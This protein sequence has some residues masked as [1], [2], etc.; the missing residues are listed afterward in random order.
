V[1]LAAAATLLAAIAVAETGTPAIAD[2]SPLPGLELPVAATDITDTDTNLAAV[3]NE[4][5]VMT[6]TEQG[7]AIHKLRAR[8][9]ADAARLASELNA[10]PGVVA[11]PNAVLAV[12]DGPGPASDAVKSAGRFA[13]DQEPALRAASVPALVSEQYGAAQWGLRAVNAEAAWS[14]TRGG[15][16]T[17]AVIDSGVDA[18]HPDLAGRLL[19]QIDLVADGWTGD[20]DGHGTHVAG[21]IAA[22]LDGV[23]VAGLANQVTVLPVRVLDATGVGDFQT[24]ALGIIEAVSAGARV[25]NL[26]LGSSYNSAVQAQAVQYAIDSGVTVIAAGGN[27]YAE[28]NPT[29]YPAALP[30]VVAVSAITPEGGS[31][32][33]ANCGSY[34]DIAAPGV[35]IL[36]TVPGVGWD[37]KDGTS[38]AAP[39]V[40]AAAA[41][42]RAGN[43][44]LTRAKVDSVLLGTVVDDADGDGRDNC[45]GEGLLQADRAVMAAA[46]MP[47][48]IRATP[49]VTQSTVPATV[50]VTAVSGKSKLKVDVNP[51]KG[52]GYWAF[53]VHKQ[54][55]DGSWQRLKTYKTR[56]SKETRTINLPRG[57]Y[58][59]V[60]NAKYGH[61]A[62]TSRPAYLKK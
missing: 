59:V 55:A 24:G 7:P 52:K 47:G 14:A 38:M 29:T 15:G 9:R 21:I 32:L 2:E 41:L 36:S 23:G 33:Y 1:A 48:G 31:W 45:F 30:G 43:P 11:E 26:S 40:S 17:V 8:S 54:R 19:P 5:V 61:A 25:I 53:Q 18:G 57:T 12:P 58:R 6:Q 34:I 13:L 20:P 49:T 10:Q 27:E 44:T 62:A 37:V 4:V 3:T 42:V 35:D 56:G 46:T 60:V 16:V 51:N 22:S 50:K 39:F 28:G